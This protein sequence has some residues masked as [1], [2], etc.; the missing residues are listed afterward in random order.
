[1]CPRRSS[2][3]AGLTL[4]ELLLAIAI[5]AVMTGVLGGLARSVQL[6]SA[7]CHG[8]GVATQHARVAF[9][10]IYW[11]VSAAK[12]T[13]D[14]PGVVVVY[15]E[16]GAF[17]FPDTLVVWRPEGAPVNANGPPLMKELVLFTPDPADPRRLWE[18]TVPNDARAVPLNETSLNT[19]AWRAELA[20]VKSAAG[21]RRVLLTDLLRTAS[22]TAAPGGGATMPNGGWSS[23]SAA[24]GAVRFASDMRP[25]A[26][27]WQ[28][29]RGGA[30][31]WAALPW[32]QGLAG[33]SAGT[34]LVTVRIEMQLM[35]GE[36][37]C[38][39]DPNGQQAVPFL[40]AASM[41]YSLRP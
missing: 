4:V 22:P 40:G 41:Y 18:I 1:M 38:R 29:Y 2:P 5:M 19:A 32:P 28:A 3:R 17:R 8:R 34:R 16:F 14:Y 35:P 7:Y 26:A 13:A 12:A 25:T 11:A 31:A 39:D 33:F 6:S 30:L 27:Q 24:R 36:E 37:A 20:A 15:E 23:T 9:D 21:S 10:R